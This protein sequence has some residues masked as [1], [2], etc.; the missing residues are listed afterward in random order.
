M[1]FWP[2]WFGL[3]ISAFTAHSQQAAV[4]QLLDSASLLWYKDFDKTSQL[5]DRAERFVEFKGDSSSLRTQLQALRLRISSCQAFSRFQLWRENLERVEKLLLDYKDELG[6]EFSLLQL[7]NEL[8]RAM[9]YVEI[10]DDARAL[11]LLVHV[12]QKFRAM[13]Q[14]IPTCHNLFLTTNYLAAIYQRRGEHKAAINQNLTGVPYYACT[15]SSGGYNAVIYR[16][17]ALNYLDIRDFT[18]ARKYLN[19]AEKIIREPLKDDPESL[20]PHALALYESQALLHEEAGNPDSALMAISKAMPLLN[21]RTIRNEFKGRIN[22][23]MATLYLERKEFRQALHHLGKAEEYFQKPG[24]QLPAFLADVY[25]A[26]ARLFERLGQ[27]EEALQYC[28]R[29]IEKLMVTAQPETSG[30][31]EQ[32]MLSNKKLFNVLEVKSLLEETLYNKHQQLSALEAALATNRQAI[33]LLDSTS[34]D[35]S[36]DEDRVN[37]K[38]QGYQAFERGI[39]INNLLYRLTGKQQYAAQVFSLM[40]M[41]KSMLLLEN[42]RVVNRFSRVSE[43]WLSREKEIKSELFAVEKS[44]YQIELGKGSDDPH[45]LRQRYADLKQEH[46]MLID[47]LRKQSPDYYRLRFDHSVVT[48]E[49]VQAKLVKPQE[50]LVEFFMGDSLLAV[51]GFTPDRQYLS[52][53]PLPSDFTASLRA[54]HSSLI[55]HS[56]NQYSRDAQ[57]LYDFLLKDCLEELGD[58]LRFLT[59]IPDG[60]LGYIPFEVLMPNREKIE[61]LNDRHAIR[62][63]YSATYLN[64]QLIRKPANSTCFFAG[65]VASGNAPADSPTR[66]N[67]LAA[68][69]GAE[70][71]IAALAKLIRY[72]LKI[73]NPARKT[74][75]IK[76]ASTFRVLH[77]AMHSVVNDENPMMSEMIFTETD[78]ISGSLTAIELYN[79]QLHS[80]LV[81]LSACNTGMGQL[82]R[83]EGIMSFARAFAYAGVPS[84]VLSLWKVPDEATS[85]IMVYFYKYL[86]NGESKDEALQR[87][88]QEFVR[89]NPEYAHPFFWSG[90]ILTGTADPVEFPVFIRWY[91]IA[92]GL[93]GLAVIVYAVRRRITPARYLSGSS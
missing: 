18:N 72:Q 17:V 15:N 37:L 64:E 28:N 12:Q 48:P 57:E 40:E 88:R 50:A 45:K 35:F 78:S 53:K 93:I 16:N 44:L 13:P 83:G 1:K 85:K 4:S 92:A 47:R 39:R 24:E 89:D 59:I 6:D 81:V 65:F 9:Y 90:F 73:F 5:L 63:A 91:W 66:G 43:E 26:K 3:V 27:P 42:L 62:Y 49:A 76:Y 25:L 8:D 61:T 30:R 20:T 34:I 21:L 79:L 58:G 68:L 86:K 2:V 23:S 70:H 55:N 84:T 71:E 22:L 31:P 51:A 19:L 60:L 75:F 77:L 11:P 69:S 87:A 29:A 56:D 41:S 74:D 10:H 38:E 33:A 36:L 54:F 80:Q 67:H 46:R 32:K 14:T 52:V 7:E 82:H